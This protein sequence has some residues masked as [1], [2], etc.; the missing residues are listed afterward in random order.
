MNR[1]LKVGN[2]ET[3]Y[4]IVEK[5]LWKNV[6]KLSKLDYDE[7]IQTYIWRSK[8]EGK[9][10]NI[11]VEQFVSRMEAKYSREILENQQ[12]IK[13]GLPA[14]EYLYKVSK[15]G[16]RFSYIV[17]VPEEIYDNCGKKIPQ[18]KGDCMEYPDVVKKFNKKINIDY[19]IKSLFGLCAHFI[20]YD[21]KYQPSP[22]SLSK[23]LD[24]KKKSKEKKLKIAKDLLQSNDSLSLDEDEIAKI[25]DEE[26]QNE[27]G[28]IRSSGASTR[29][30][31][32]FNALDKI[33]DSTCSKLLDLLSKLSKLNV[34]Y[35]NTMYDLITQA[36]K[37]KSKI[38]ILEQVIGLE[39]SWLQALSITYS[40]KKDEPSDID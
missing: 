27:A 13:K 10:G 25:K 33:A 29:Y 24:R 38:T 8:K 40:S 16:E 4:Q 3:I 7:F 11:S 23:V 31:D 2:E 15:S 9:R 17:V 30:N 14:N 19:Y 36:Q 35:R 37:H 5:V 28:I 1:T 12:L 39:I 34:E 32:Y 20:N 26:S 6:E 21:D 18:Q 22:E